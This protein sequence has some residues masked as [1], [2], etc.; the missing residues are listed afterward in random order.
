MKLGLQ[1]R[2]LLVSNNTP[3][4]HNLTLQ[5]TDDNSNSNSNYRG[6]SNSM[7]DS[8]LSPDD[9]CPEQEGRSEES[10][11]HSKSV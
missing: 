5:V 3:K 10:S 7:L 1:N 4:K 9:I 11:T 8:L 6:N 2:K